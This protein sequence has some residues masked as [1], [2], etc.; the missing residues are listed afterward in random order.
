MMDKI[1]LSHYD[2]D[3][4]KRGT[5]F[6]HRV[7]LGGQTSI[8]LRWL[9]A[10]GISLAQVDGDVLTAYLKHRKTQGNKHLTLLQ[11]LAVLR[12]FFR[13]LVERKIV[14]Q[15]PTEGI[16]IRWLD[17]PGGV[18]GYK[19]TLRRVLKAPHYLWKFR[20]PL[21]APHWESYINYLVD[22]KYARHTLFHVMEQNSYFHLYLTE[23]RIRDF[24]RI[25][26]ELLRAYLRYNAKRF[27]EEHGYSLS[28]SY[29]RLINGAI[30]NFLMFAFRQRGRPFFPSRPKQEN[31][32]LSDSLLD[33]HNDFCRIHKGLSPV[34]LLGYRRYLLSF[35]LFLNSRGIR[36]LEAITIGECDTFLM[37]QAGRLSP[38]SLQ[39]IISA[40]RS[41]FRFLHLHGEIRSDIARGLVSPSRF[42]SDTRP[43]YLP[44][45]KIQRLLASIDRSRNAGKRDYAILMLLAHHGLRAREAAAL[46]ISDIDW[47][48]HS[49]FLRHR[50]NGSSVQM[51]LS[52]QTEE[53]LRLYLTVRSPCPAPEI[54]L[55]EIAPIKPLKRS[56]YAVAQRHIWNVFGKLPFSQGAH[57]LR[58]SFAKALLDRGAKLHE[59]GVLLGHRSLR[60]TQI[61]TRIA[62]EEL[63]EVADNY[64]N[65]L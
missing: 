14:D 3:I 27:Q 25:T 43:K 26:P 4:K 13:Y 23:K 9:A 34:T 18:M 30:K 10:Q 15:N 48:K 45:P 35:R 36:R 20:L 31:T 54:F 7:L 1:L 62:T 2:K 44:W 65:L 12:H 56:L 11:A 53:A 22:Q 33:R 29:R 32:V 40:L 64:A 39:Y 59:V 42:R 50:K 21:F 24:S 6:W 52:P 41:F 63:R 61:Y 46:R 57:L 51:P 55:T 38:K 17:I 5:K 49:M 28:L 60:S 16:S 8:F 47:D 58:H 19:G 37:K